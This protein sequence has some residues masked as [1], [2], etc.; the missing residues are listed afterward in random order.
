MYM[1]IFIQQISESRIRHET[2]LRQ[3]HHEVKNVQVQI[4]LIGEQDVRSNSFDSITN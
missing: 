3:C 4:C 1:Y 2:Q